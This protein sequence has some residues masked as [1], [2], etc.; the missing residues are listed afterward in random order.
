MI[1]DIPRHSLNKVILLQWADRS[2]QPVTR[3]LRWLLIVFTFSDTPLPVPYPDPAPGGCLLAEPVRIVPLSFHARISLLPV[4]GR[5]GTSTRPI[6]RFTGDERVIFFQKEPYPNTSWPQSHFPV[7]GWKMTPPALQN[8]LYVS[9]WRY[10]LPADTN[11]PCR[12]R[13][14]SHFPDFCPLRHRDPVQGRV[15]APATQPLHIRKAGEREIWHFCFLVRIYYLQCKGIKTWTDIQG[16][17]KVYFRNFPNSLSSYD[18][19]E[20]FLVHP[21]ITTTFFILWHCK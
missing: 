10:S 16:H 4:Q 9:S 3:Y 2:A 20:I 18:I 6:L 12:R 11:R 8:P 17:A 1:R 13:G 14:K 21:C 15:T 19:P 5:Q 7:Q